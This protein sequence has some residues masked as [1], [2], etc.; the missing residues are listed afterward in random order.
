MLIINISINKNI[1]IHF[2]DDSEKNITC[3]DNV[4]S[5]NI[6]I[7]YIDKHKNPKIYLTKILNKI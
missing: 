5:N 2:I 7:Y 4:K 6:K 3:V 1:K